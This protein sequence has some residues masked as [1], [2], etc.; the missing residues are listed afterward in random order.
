VPSLIEIHPELFELS[1]TQVHTRYQKYIYNEHVADK[2]S[3]AK[4]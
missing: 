4:D 3:S 2:N 1:I